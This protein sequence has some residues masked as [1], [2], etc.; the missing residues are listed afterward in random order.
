[1]K[2]K[3]TFSIWPSSSVNFGN[4]PNKML[5]PNSMKWVHVQKLH[6]TLQP[7]EFSPPNIGKGFWPKIAVEAEDFSQNCQIKYSYICFTISSSN[8]FSWPR[9]DERFSSSTSSWPNT[10][11][12][13]NASTPSWQDLRIS[14]WIPSHTSYLSFFLHSQFFWRIEF[15]PKNANF[16]R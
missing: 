4:I 5:P 13:I 6:K 15:T 1:M 14:K 16:S 8:L 10:L 2:R 3:C 12:N 11:L 9:N 7:V